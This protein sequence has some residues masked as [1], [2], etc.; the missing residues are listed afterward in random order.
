MTRHSTSPPCGNLV[1]GLPHDCHNIYYLNVTKLVTTIKKIFKNIKPTTK[2]TDL[3]EF[4][5]TGSFS[6]LYFQLQNIFSNMFIKFE[7]I[8]IF[9][10][11]SEEAAGLF[12]QGLI[13]HRS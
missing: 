10:H 3:L 9:Q 4:L 11:F 7:K 2:F 1:D 8:I 13:D 6:N 5:L 12:G